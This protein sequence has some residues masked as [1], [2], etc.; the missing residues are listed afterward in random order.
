MKNIQGD[1]SDWK[2]VGLQIFPPGYKWN[3]KHSQLVFTQNC[4]RAVGASSTRP[5]SSE[6]SFGTVWNVAVNYIWAQGF[7][8]SGVIKSINHVV[9]LLS[10]CCLRISGSK[11]QRLFIH[12]KKKLDINYSGHMV[13]QYAECTGLL[14]HTHTPSAKLG[15]M[16]V[17]Y[18]C[19]Y[20]YKYIITPETLNT[21][22][23]IP[24]TQCVSVALL[25]LRAGSFLLIDRLWTGWGA[26]HVWK[27]QR[28]WMNEKGNNYYKSKHPLLPN[29]RD[30]V[31][32]TN[33]LQIL[34]VAGH[35]YLPLSVCVLMH[36]LPPSLPRQRDVVSG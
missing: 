31:G 16:K 20:Q 18:Y 35:H 14:T 12:E 34:R 2:P 4:L 9:Q 15:C 25:W 17:T 30:Y 33:S 29:D 21:H 8:S 19:I 1:K 13:L 24:L 32:Q 6:R 10:T 27:L 5:A 26:P 7:S 28:R 36:G 3:S 22:T 23:L 11:W